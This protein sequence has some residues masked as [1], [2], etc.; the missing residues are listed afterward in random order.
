MNSE[1][2]LKSAD[3]EINW[4]RYYALREDR[5]KLD[6]S[7]PIYEQLRSIG[8]AKVNT[9]LDLRCAGYRSIK[10]EEGKSIEEMEEFNQLRMPEEN[11]FT[12]LEV[13]S[14]LS[15]GLNAWIYDRINREEN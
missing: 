2:L 12:P 10:F 3:Q 7:F 6:L 4:L 9:R 1:E 13:L 8:Y 11:I 14:K 15:P 5:V